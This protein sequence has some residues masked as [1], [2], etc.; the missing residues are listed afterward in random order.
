[1]E[2]LNKGEMESYG[3]ILHSFEGHTHHVLGVAWQYNGR[4]L[5]SV[6]ADNEIKVWNVVTGERAGKFGVGSKEVTSIQFVGYSDNAVVTA[7]DNRVR[8]VSIPMG[9]PKNIRD[10]SGSTD[11]VYSGSISAD[12]NIVAAGGADAVLRIWNGVNGASIAS[13][14]APM[15]QE[16]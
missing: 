16:R 1:M 6:G 3:K 8:R 11:Y 4:V 13:F 9:N 15:I 14:G 12:G 5:A 7:G 2:E 10:F